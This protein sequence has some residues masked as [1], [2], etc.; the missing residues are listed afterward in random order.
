[1]ISPRPECNPWVPGERALS[2]GRIHREHQRP[3]GSPPRVPSFI[4][5][6][7]TVSDGDAW[8][9]EQMSGLF[10][11]P[12]GRDISPQLSWSD[13]P[14]GTK[15]YAVTVYDPDAPTGSGSG[16]WHWAVADIPATVTQLPRVPVTRPSGPAAVSTARFSLRLGRPAIRRLGVGAVGVRQHQ[17]ALRQHRPHL[18]SAD[19]GTGA[20]NQC[21][22]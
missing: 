14:E 22:G 4:V 21:F 11:V 7:T 20:D 18:P 8:P 10:G 9:A 16:F 19:I 3:V 13:A 1:M 2:T 17:G 5:T 12:A 15:S 6:S